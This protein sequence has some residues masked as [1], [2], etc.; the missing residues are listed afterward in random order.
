MG[1]GYKAFTAGSVLTA[2]DVNNYL[3]E[4]GVMYFATTTARD[5]AITAPEDGM[6]V[7]IGSNDANEGL[8]TY[9]GTSWRKGPGWNAPWGVVATTAGGTSSRSYAVTTT[10]TSTTTS[11]TDW[12]GLT[13]T[14]TGIANRI[15]QTIVHGMVTSDNA[16]GS[17]YVE[18]VL[19][20]ASNNVLTRSRS[21]VQLGVFEGRSLQYVEANSTGSLT[22]KVSV[23]R[24]SGSGNVSGYAAAGF[25]AS[26]TLVDIGPSGAPV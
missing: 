13:V 26:I 17:D 10:A 19:R 12:S 15:Y 22:R 14:F 23:T 24:A 1:S 6:V 16:S 20:D 3:M 7:Y 5:T 21:I 8:W 2:S 4:Q 18:L 25:Q 11:T 9:N